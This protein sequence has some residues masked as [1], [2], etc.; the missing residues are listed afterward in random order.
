VGKIFLPESG[1]LFRVALFM[2]KANT[3][4]SKMQHLVESLL[5]VSKI[6]ADQLALNKTQFRIAEMIDDCCDHIRMAG[7]HKLELTGD[8]GLEVF[9]DK[10]RIDQVIVNLVN[11]AVKYAPDSD[12]I[13]INVAREDQF[14]RVSVQDFGQGIPAEKIPL[15]F[16]RYFRVDASGMQYSGLGLGLYIC[17]DIIERHG[18]KI[19][20]VSQPGEGS[21]FWFTLPLE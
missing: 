21:T 4:L 2:E 7:K 10:E 17:S 9:A 19:G 11:N 14:V 1:D 8:L 6:A 18:G 15:L 5:H 3:S 13:I 16:D 20:V 12:Q